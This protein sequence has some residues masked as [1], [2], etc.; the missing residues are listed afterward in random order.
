M[1]LYETARTFARMDP[2]SSTKMFQQKVSIVTMLMMTIMM[3]KVLKPGG[4]WGNQRK[5]RLKQ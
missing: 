1:T 2:W 5:E 4:G 3:L